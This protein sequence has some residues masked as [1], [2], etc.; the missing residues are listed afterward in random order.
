MRAELAFPEITVHSFDNT[1][2]GTSLPPGFAGARVRH[3]VKQNLTS[4][5]LLVLKTNVRLAHQPPDMAANGNQPPEKN[6]L[7]STNRRSKQ[8]PSQHSTFPEPEQQQGADTI[9]K[10]E[11]RRNFQRIGENSTAGG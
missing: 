11:I 9:I 4:P 3:G 6:G 7:P 5:N 8:Q 10:R 2:E 1:E